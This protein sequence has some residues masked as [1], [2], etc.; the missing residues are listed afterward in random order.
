[1]RKFNKLFKKDENGKNREWRDIEENKIRELHQK[2]KAQMEEVI[3]D[4]KFIKLPKA[5]LT[6]IAKGN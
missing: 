6:S 2:C 4:F 1:L 5:G 3:N